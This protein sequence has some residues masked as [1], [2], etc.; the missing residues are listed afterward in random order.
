[1]RR[2]RE[3]IAFLSVTVCS[4]LGAC[5]ELAGVEGVVLDVPGGSAGT[6]AA[7]GS[8][9]SAGSA[10]VG[11]SAG[12]ICNPSGS[13]CP[14]G[15]TAGSSGGAGDAGGD[16]SA[17]GSAGGDAAGAEGADSAG[18]GGADSAAEGAAGSDA[19]VDSPPPCVPLGADPSEVYVDSAAA[20]GGTGSIG[21]PLRT[22]T[23]GLSLLM[24]SSAPSRTL[25][26]AAGRYDGALGESFPLVVTKGVRIVGAGAKLTSI[27]G[28]G[29]YDLGPYGVTVT[30]ALPVSLLIR[31]EERVEING[32]A[33]AGTGSVGSSIYG[34]IAVGGNASQSDP[35]P[36]PFPEPSSLLDGVEISG[37]YVGV[38]ASNT[39]TSGAN[40][41]MVRSSIVHN[42]IGVLA[43]GCGFSQP[44]G[45][46][47][48]LEIGGSTA[49]G[50]IFTNNDDY[51]ALAVWGCVE[52]LRVIGNEFRDNN[53]G[54][55]LDEYTSYES[56]DLLPVLRD[57]T[58]ASNSEGGVAI[59]HLGSVA[60]LE[61]NRFEGNVAPPSSTSAAMGVKLGPSGSDAVSPK[62]L[63]A[64]G[65]RFIGNDVGLW[66]WANGVIT[67]GL[68]DFGRPG[69]PGNNVFRCN[70]SPVAQRTGFDV[71]LDPDLPSGM[72]VHFAGNEWDHTPPTERIAAPE[73]APNGADLLKTA[74]KAWTLDVTGSRLATV[75]CPNGFPPGP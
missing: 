15:G 27:R 8:A 5:A 54:L 39:R 25:R 1:M 57:N 63:R 33:L 53:L 64:R 34:I 75:P 29:I 46:M 28:F 36:T 52:R 74:N 66:F 44:R 48:A 43:Q 35:P 67:D 61:N 41:R 13:M 7:G 60:L 42:R 3:R 11:G 72:I 50:N 37:Y 9:G 4:A 31:S 62:I 10:A 6:G 65:N 73:A 24:A 49:D 16:V 22:V 32:L 26:V 47:V 2:F 68:V 55:H 59:H 56:P 20:L 17:G 38:L 12:S 14:T 58:F 18:A 71:G 21:C 19:G 51:V 69:D 40:L 23:A 45:P 70:G 30:S